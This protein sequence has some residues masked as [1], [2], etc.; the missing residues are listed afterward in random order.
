MNS[1]SFERRVET[2]AGSDKSVQRVFYLSLLCTLGCS[3]GE[4][5][6][7]GGGTKQNEILKNEKSIL[8]QKKKKKENNKKERKKSKEEM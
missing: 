5:E 4:R 7:G 6:R 3:I 8:K 2:K 1:A